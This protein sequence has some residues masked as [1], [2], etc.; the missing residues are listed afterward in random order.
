M[1]AED[2]SP[3]FNAEQLEECDR[4]PDE[5]LITA[6]WL[7]GESHQLVTMVCLFIFGHFIPCEFP[8]NYR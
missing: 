8:D 3:A 2:T 4:H 7:N 6:Y 5:E 1:A